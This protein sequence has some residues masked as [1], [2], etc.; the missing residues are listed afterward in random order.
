MLATVGVRMLSRVGVGIF[1]GG[2]GLTTSQEPHKSCRHCSD[3]DV[4]NL[5]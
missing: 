2:E 4:G 3:S 5:L 1:R